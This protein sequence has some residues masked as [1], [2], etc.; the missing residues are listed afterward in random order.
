MKAGDTDDFPAL[1]DKLG[2]PNVVG[3]VVGSPVYF[4][5]M[6]ALCKAFLDRCG[7]FRKGGFKLSNK[8][9]GVV[10]VGGARNGG[11][12]FPGKL[13]QALYDPTDSLKLGQLVVRARRSQGHDVANPGAIGCLDARARVL[14]DHTV[15][16][17]QTEFA[18]RLQITIR[19][20]LARF[21]AVIVHDALDL[22][23]PIQT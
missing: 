5:N 12:P 22:E 23:P 19:S 14:H 21:G 4:G 6:S 9:A 3:I 11:Q 2:A 16:W 1:A 10:A 15:G 13:V 8:V 20:G 7:V 17:I 18:G